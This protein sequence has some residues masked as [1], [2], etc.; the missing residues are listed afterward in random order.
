MKQ[1]TFSPCLPPSTKKSILDV[2]NLIHEFLQNNCRISDVSLKRFVVDEDRYQRIAFDFSCANNSYT[3]AFA[4][5]QLIFSDDASPAYFMYKL[6]K[7]DGDK[8]I[9]LY[10]VSDEYGIYSWTKTYEWLEQR[11]NLTI[12]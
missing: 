5:L 9:W 1:I 10:A 3:K 6:H 4:L 2:V 7:T 8:G 12:R 11:M